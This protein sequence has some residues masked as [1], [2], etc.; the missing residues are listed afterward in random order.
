MNFNTPFK[1]Q[2][3]NYTNNNT[4]EKISTSNYID[5]TDI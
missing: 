5:C 2:K 1:F 3:N 4:K